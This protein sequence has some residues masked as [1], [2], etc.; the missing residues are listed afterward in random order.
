MNEILNS[1]IP[2]NVV[3]KIQKLLALGSHLNDS[4]EEAEKAMAKAIKLATEYDLDLTT[5]SAFAPKPSD[6][7]CIESEEINLGKRL[8]IAEKYVCHIVQNFFKCSI[9]YH[10]GRYYGRRVSFIGK[11]KDIEIAN[12]IYNYLN[13]TFM[14]LWK[15]YYY[16]NEKDIRLEERGSFF[17]GL[18]DSI[19]EKLQVAKEETE[20]KKFEE[21]EQEKGAEVVEEIKNQ[22]ALVAVNEKKRVADTVKQIYPRLGT[23]QRSYT[24]IKSRDAYAD[25][26]KQ[27]R[28]IHLGK[29]LNSS[30]SGQ[31]R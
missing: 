4:R 21:I 14:K 29:A 16:Q 1:N 22:Y 28:N 31:L 6:E 12:Y 5:I 30:G 9:I 19:T 26:Q 27:G 8:P 25:G 11:K 13:T 18:E 23:I 17:K 20:T 15:D 2:D 7:P 3:K 24:G 10:G